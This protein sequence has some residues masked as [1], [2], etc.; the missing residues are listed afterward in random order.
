MRLWQDSVRANFAGITPVG[1]FLEKYMPPLDSMGKAMICK[2]SVASTMKLEK[3]A[4]K[5]P[6]VKQEGDITPYLIDYLKALVK[7]L[8]KKRTPAIA[9]THNKRFP[10]LNSETHYT[11]PDLTSI[12]PGIEAPADW[13]WSHAG[14]VFELKLKVDIF[15][16]DGINKSEKSK[17]A[18]V[19]LAESARSLLMASRSCFVFVVA[20]WRCNARIF[21]FDRSGFRASSTFDWTKQPNIFATFFY[22]LYTPDVSGARVHGDD[23][24]ISVPSPADKKSMYKIL[25]AN[26]LYGH[27][28]F[29][30]LEHS[31]WVDAVMTEDGESIPVRCFTV[32]PPLSQADGLFCR[33]TW[34]DR[35]LVVKKGAP[36]KDAKG[37]VY[38]LKDSWRNESRR[39]EVDFY[40]VIRKHCVENDIDCKGMAQCHGSVDL[41]LDPPF[42]PSLDTSHHRTCSAVKGPHRSED[43]PLTF[44]DPNDADV[45]QDLDD[46]GDHP[47][48]RRH[49]RALLTPVGLPLNGYV[50]SKHLVAAL[51]NALRHH[52]IAF[53]AGVLHRDV[54]EGNVLFDEA[55]LISI[56]SEKEWLYQGFLVDW[57]YAEFT[58]KGFDAFKTL[59]RDDAMEYQEVH[60]SL[61]NL[62]G[63]FAFLALQLL[64]AAADK[65]SI[66]HT[67]EHDLESFYWLLVW[68]I[69]RHNT[70][71]G[72][73]AG[74]LACHQLFDAATDF[75]AASQKGEWLLEQLPMENTLLFSV[76][77]ALRDTLE[78][79]YAYMHE[80][81]KLEK[82]AP[83]IRQ[84]QRQQIEKVEI[85]HAEWLGIL[86]EALAL[87]NWPKDPAVDLDPPSLR[88]QEQADPDSQSLLMQA[89]HNSSKRRLEDA[90]V[91]VVS[92]GSP[93]ETKASNSSERSTES[94][95]K[96]RRTNAAVET[97]EVPTAAIS[98]RKPTRKAGGRR[99]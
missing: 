27:W 68:I 25:T 50:S 74:L 21:R 51:Q 43:D 16:G 22:G 71:H 94:A 47:Y 14:T 91:T 73:P 26:P 88:K 52:K 4:A 53:E 24:T 9:D 82:P 87:D 49:M 77:E 2:M 34:V 3:A 11:M 75:H 92:T 56:K 23:T 64:R 6:N 33:A 8:P 28:G 85:T 84:R 66:T 99:P 59:G 65:R 70:N 60:K 97:T 89:V 96:K 42:D 79:H 61:K 18:L 45:S 95:K 40:D 62:T 37:D 36:L 15:D 20:V 41:S 5:V 83:L 1:E 17:E 63:T 39:P 10:S 86:D 13:T 35:V 67:V 81:Q 29:E 80:Q 38:A 72:H 55:A 44:E 46:L 30:Y 69:L 54:S 12:R 76:V 57:D 32:G 48:E 90:S 19:Q 7:L 31:R 78:H 93:S 98:A 58:D